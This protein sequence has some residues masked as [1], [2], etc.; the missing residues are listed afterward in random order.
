MNRTGLYIALALSL[1][2]GLTFGIY[3]ELDLKLAALFYDAATK[4][5][6]IKDGAVAMFARDAAMWIC[7]AFVL[8]SIAALILKLIWPNR[9]LL[10]SANTIAFLLITITL[11]AG[12]LTNLTFK[13][14]WGRPRPVMVTEFSGPWQF[15]AWWDP[16]GQCG[17]NCSFFS[18]EGATAFWT[19]A[20]A[21]LTPPAVRPV[22]YVAAFVFGALTSGL[23]M[24]FGGHFFTDVAIAGL[25]T[26]LVI[27]L[28]HGWIYR[29]PATRKTDAEAEARL[30]RFAWPGYRWRRKLLSGQDVGPAP[31]PD[32]APRH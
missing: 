16:T 26:F 25:V 22:A 8:P 29:W 11:A 6:P 19:F 15:K 7:W 31:E 1:V 14:H 18:G 27:W 21:A 12:I 4:T 13:T 10:V 3:P 28:V 9:K 5:F 20:P 30:T 32:T 17:R 24:A 23:R 2:V